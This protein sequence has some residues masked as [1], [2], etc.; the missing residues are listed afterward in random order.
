MLLLA[1]LL[2][3]DRDRDDAD[4]PSVQTGDGL[5]LQGCPEEGRATARTLRDPV[6]RPWGED[7]LAEP[8]DALLLSSRAAF[9]ISAPETPATYYHYGGIPIDAVALAGCEQAGPERLGELGFVV[10]QLDLFDFTA[11][12][13]RQVRGETIE[14]VSDGSDGG[15]AV[16]EVTGT[17]DRFWLVELDLVRA[18][19]EDGE[20]RTLSDLYGLEITTRYTLEP[21]A[22]VLQLEV[23]L[24]GEP[25]TDGFLVGLLLIPS[26]HT[27]LRGFSTGGLSVGGFSLDT[28]VPWIS[29]GGADGALAVAM[30]GAQSAFTSVSGVSALLDVGQA[31]SPMEVLG[32]TSPPGT[33]FLLSVSAGDAAS[34]GAALEP[35]LDEPIPGQDVGWADLAGM[36]LDPDGAPVADA[37]VEVYAED[38]AT[39]LAALRTDADGAFA[40][41]LLDLGGPWQ[42]RGAAEGRDDGALV[43]VEPN[44]SDFSLEMGAAGAIQVTVVD[45]TGQPL[46]ARVELERDDGTIAVRYALPGDDALPLPP[47]TWT[48]WVSRGY[49]HEVAETTVTVPEGGEGSLEVVLARALDTEGWAS[50]D[51]HVHMEPSPDSTTLPEERMRTAAAAGLDVV[52]STDHEAIVDLS[53]AIQSAGV[54]DFLS[55]ALGSEVTATLPE[56]VNAWP[57]PPEAA[58]ARG[59]PV[60]WYGLPFSGIYEAIRERGATVI[61]LNHSRVNGECGILCILDWDRMSETPTVEDPTALGLEAGAEIW[62]WDFDS[63]EVMNGLRSP[64]LKTEDTRRS[65]ALNDWMAFHNLGHRVTGVAVTDVHGLDIP[66]SPRTWVRVGDDSPG[67]VG[68]EELAEGVLA[69]AAVI[70]AGAFATVAVNGAGPGELATGQDGSFALNLQVQALPEIDVARVYVVANCNLFSTLDATDPDANVKLDITTEL[71]LSEDAWVITIG[72]GEG[73]MPRG[74]D[75]YD[76]SA[77]PRFITNPVFV[78]ADGDGL[79]TAPGPRA[80]DWTP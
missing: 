48:A 22:D 63:F 44:T 66:G 11:S 36:L 25:V 26:D 38:G 50:M 6:E 28:G 72:Q 9:V 23:L 60:R 76:P 56:H 49:E 41:R 27:E 64:F 16:V 1:L 55:Y 52:V 45:E 67:Q 17:D 46:P 37:T 61:Q 13:L 10:G 4:T 62:S 33:P 78:D 34:A 2:A 3:C 20:P 68:A 74:L 43:E 15:P 71:P 24:D 31:L 47:G 42:V 21:D 32:A 19:Y 80:C 7:A 59:Q 77:V 35:W 65:G 18:A 58:V 39:L 51:T 73:E 14:V 12:S 79:W 5:L 53:D 29:M 70:S 40:G 75:D 30:P 69:G 8:G 54:S 57:F